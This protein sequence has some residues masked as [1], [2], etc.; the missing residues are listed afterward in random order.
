MRKLVNYQGLTTFFLPLH[1]A[2]VVSITCFRQEG[3]NTFVKAV[4]EGQTSAAVYF[5]NKV[6]HGISGGGTRPR[7][8]ISAPCAHKK[9][10]TVVA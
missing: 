6:N 4:C 1:A 3:N 2:L 9:M 8:L 5:Q 7:L 10:V